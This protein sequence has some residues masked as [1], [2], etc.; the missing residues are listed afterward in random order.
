MSQQWADVVDT[1]RSWIA[2]HWNAKTAA[3]A[4]VATAAGMAVVYMRITTGRT[5][6]IADALTV[7]GNEYDRLMADRKRQLFS[8]LE[9]LKDARG[10]G[11]LVLLEIGC[12]GGNNFA[13]YPVGSE[14]ICVEPN[15]HFEAALYESV[16]QHPGV[17]ISAFHVLAAENMQEVQSGSVDAVVSTTV[18]CSVTNPDQCIKVISVR[19][20]L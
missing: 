19:K 12:G 2:E 20:I 4:A 18:L 8:E 7:I 6:S 15:R 17:Q 10:D 9:S 14:V 1:V 11:R 16:R 13:Y 5:Q 3:V